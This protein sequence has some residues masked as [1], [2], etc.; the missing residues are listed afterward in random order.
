MKNFKFF[1]VFVSVLALG[2]TFS[3]CSDDEENAD[4]RDNMVGT[5][6]YTSKSYLLVDDELQY[7][8]SENDETGT[9][10]VK[11][12]DGNATTVD[13]YEGAN[14][15]FQ[16]N[17]IVEAAN[18]L[19]FDIPSQNYS[20]DGVTVTIVGYDYWDLSGTSYQGA[21]L[22]ATKKIESAFIYSIEVEG[23]EL[24]IVETFEGTKQ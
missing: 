15:V 11:K 21:Y 10:T 4:I 6:N 1:L 3:S 5:Y 16:G 19:A 7:T 2:F 18:G 8:G 23:V 17:K 12:N 24:V 20:E 14:L 9:F 22:T 13:F